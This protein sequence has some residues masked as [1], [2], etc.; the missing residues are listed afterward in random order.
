MASFQIHIV[1]H[2][3]GCTSNSGNK[4]RCG[5]M[6][7]K[8]A[9]HLC[10]ECSATGVTALSACKTSMTHGPP[11]LRAR[12]RISVCSSVSEL[13][14]L[15][16]ERTASVLHRLI[17]CWRYLER[18][19]CSER[20]L[21]LLHKPEEAAVNMDVSSLENTWEFAAYQQIC[22]LQLSGRTRL[23]LSPDWSIRARISRA[24]PFPLNAPASWNPWITLQWKTPDIL[25][26]FL[27]SKAI[28]ASPCC[29]V[30]K[31]TLNF[32]PPVLKNWELQGLCVNTDIC[33]CG[34]QRCAGF[35]DLS[36]TAL[37]KGITY[38]LSFGSSV[39]TSSC[40][41]LLKHKLHWYKCFA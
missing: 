40:N 20:E 33:V 29:H 18:R 2:F 12:L 30:S 5:I 28:R 36:S 7:C 19:R 8:W 25:G 35:Y 9:V 16:W 10:P 23:S 38:T 22:I 24:T 14:A 4:R 41:S 37:I 21:T 27:C 26:E 1:K 13:E 31:S 17:W 39:P 15:S 3:Q 34:D 6:T 11:E 32:F